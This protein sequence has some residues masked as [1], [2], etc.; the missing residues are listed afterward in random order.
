MMK[1]IFFVQ[2]K[3][4]F[5]ATLTDAKLDRPKLKWHHLWCERYSSMKWCS[6]IHRDISILSLPAISIRLVNFFQ[7][8]S[9]KFFHLNSFTIIILSSIDVCRNHRA[10]KLNDFVCRP[11]GR[12]A[13]EQAAAPEGVAWPHVLALGDCLGHRP[14][15]SLRQEWHQKPWIKK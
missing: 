8:R 4:Y 14:T 10:V 5:F 6:Y 9:I 11:P 13:A 15:L 2:L 12:L 7:F 1:I 3:F